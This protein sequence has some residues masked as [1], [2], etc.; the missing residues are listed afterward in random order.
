MPEITLTD[1]PRIEDLRV[2]TVLPNLSANITG[3]LRFWD[4]SLLE[5]V[6]AAEQRGALVEKTDY[7][8][9]F[10]DADDRLVFPYDNSPRHPEISTHPHHKHTGTTAGQD[11]RLEAAFPPHLGNVLREIDSYLQVRRK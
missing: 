8:Y 10:Q 2:R 3:R 4:G 1:Q 5:F 7:A 6:E 9:H 11:E